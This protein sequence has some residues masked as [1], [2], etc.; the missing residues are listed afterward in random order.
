MCSTILNKSEPGLFCPRF[1]DQYSDIRGLGVSAS[2]G[3]ILVRFPVAA[4]RHV[5]PFLR[6]FKNR[7][8][9]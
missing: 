7:S 5:L 9:I 6:P 2:P 1:C 3:T 4:T 8:A